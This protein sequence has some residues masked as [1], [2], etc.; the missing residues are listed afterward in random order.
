MESA[1]SPIRKTFVP[2]KDTNRSIISIRRNK[3]KAELRRR[4]RWNGRGQAL[5]NSI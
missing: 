1:S 3:A 5:T 4:I 2:T